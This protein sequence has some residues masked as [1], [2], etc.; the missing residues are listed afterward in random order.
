MTTPA[1]VEVEYIPPTCPPAQIGPC[2]SARCTN[3]T[4]RYG[5]RTP[6]SP[7]RPLCN[8]CFAKLEAKRASSS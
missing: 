4:Q 8:V 3:K 6:E 7:T 2:R 5:P 1:P